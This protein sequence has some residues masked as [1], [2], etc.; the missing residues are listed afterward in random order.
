MLFDPTLAL[1]SH[2]YPIRFVPVHSA[3]T[4]N[5]S[6]CGVCPRALIVLAVQHCTQP[7]PLVIDAPKTPNPGQAYHPSGGNEKLGQM[8]VPLCRA[9][10][11]FISL[12]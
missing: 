5:D 12:C 3:N 2:C 1:V 7:W 8:G 6:H 4:L 11:I 9:Y 10:Q